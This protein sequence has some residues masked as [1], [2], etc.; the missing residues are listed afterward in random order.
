MAENAVTPD[1]F[2]EDDGRSRGPV[3]RDQLVELLAQNFIPTTARVWTANFGQHWRTASEA[4]LVP[5]PSSPPPLPPLLSLQDGSPPPLSGL[6]ENVPARPTAS[7]S[8]S[9]S[10][11]NRTVGNL[12]DIEST[13]VA[14][15]LTEADLAERTSQ[16]PS[17]F[18]PSPH[19][20]GAT[21]V[22][23][24]AS[25]SDVHLFAYLLAFSPLA[26]LAGDLLM[27]SQGIDPYGDSPVAGGATLWSIIGTFIL[28]LF[29]A[30]RIKA[31]GLNPNGSALVPFLLL[32]H[33]G[34]FIRRNAL[35]PGSLK[36]L[37]IWLGSGVVFLFIA[38][39][40]LPE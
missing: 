13:E 37:W 31:A 9:R 5:V 12:T 25:S 35:V 39:S 4:N 33:I 36:F 29:D 14:P 40:L 28:A 1:W 22:A 10:A 24:S 20:A 21:P 34:Y 15:L 7:K 26:I 2:Y 3:T 18:R 30:K 19:V 23:S 8:G 27:A 17:D 11:Q 6:L 32:T 38:A 16:T